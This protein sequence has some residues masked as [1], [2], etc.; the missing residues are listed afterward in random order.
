MSPFPQEHVPVTL[1]TIDVSFISLKHVLPSVGALAA[2]GAD[3]VTL[4]KPQ[5]EAGREEVGKHGIVR[6]PAVHERVVRDVADAATSLGFHVRD[7]I[8]SPIAGAEGNRE[9]FLHLSCP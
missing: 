3:V 7:S 9:F 8:P 4:V 1:V 2:P 5:F 6:D